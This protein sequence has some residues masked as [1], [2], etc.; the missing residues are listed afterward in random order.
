MLLSVVASLAAALGVSFALDFDGPQ[1]TEYAGL[2][3]RG[4]SPQPTAAP[5]YQ[6]HRRKL[7]KRD[8]TDTCAYVN[9]AALTCPSGQYCAYGTAVPYMGCCTTDANGQFDSGCQMTTS[10]VN[11]AESSLLCP[12][13][14]TA[15][16]PGP[17]TGVWYVSLLF[18]WS[19]DGD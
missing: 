16:C 7:Q 14:S 4:F 17:L 1:A 10:C 19:E 9:G 2:D 18:F 3:P 6:L 12:V 8:L 11:Q 5:Y 15:A 13:A